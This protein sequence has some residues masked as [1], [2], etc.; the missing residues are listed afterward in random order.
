MDKG[1]VVASGHEQRQADPHPHAP[2]VCLHQAVSRTT[3]IWSSATR[4]RSMALRNAG[5]D[6]RLHQIA[7]EAGA[8]M[9]SLHTAWRTEVLFEEAL[10]SRAVAA[11]TF[12]LPGDSM[13]VVNKY[14]QRVVNEKRDYNDR[15]MVHFVYDPTREE[16]PNQ[17]L[18]MLFESAAD[19]WRRLPV[20]GPARR[21]P[22]DAE[23]RHLGRTVREARRAAR[24]VGPA[25]RWRSAGRVRGQHQ[26][27]VQ[28]CRLRAR[29]RTRFQ[30]GLHTYDTQWHKLFSGVRAGNS[31]G[32]NPHPN[33]TMHP[34]A[35]QG[36]YHAHPGAW[37]ARHE[38]G[39][40]S[41]STR[42][43]GS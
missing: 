7:Q 30:R 2:R 14:G 31:F 43:C 6:R 34:F 9:G 5:F 19:R 15:T 20:P 37:R 38:R 4:W 13:I 36:P 41:T 16:Y 29:V 8:R 32:A 40:A 11:G 10:A 35:D 26:D 39:P 33:L 23:R 1:R 27:V 25:H 17:L 12:V 22:L 18:F 28:S 21:Q 42:R 24:P 3:S